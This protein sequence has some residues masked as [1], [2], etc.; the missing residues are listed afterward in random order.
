MKIVTMCRGGNVRS[1]AAKMILSRCLRH[2]VIAIG[3]D[4]TN[5]DTKRFLFNWADRIVIMHPDLLKYVSF[6]YFD[7][8]GGRP[9]LD[10][11]YKTT[12]L[13]VGNDVWGNP[14][15][16]NLQTTIVSLINSNVYSPLFDEKEGIID[17]AEVIKTL[18]E[19]KAKLE[20]RNI[21]FD[22]DKQ[23]IKRE[24]AYE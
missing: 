17:L 2:E 22:I 14:F 4:N 6:T 1:V 8:Y 9:R 24:D 13:N 20:L 19:Y 10:Y 21:R 5:Y 23:I 11:T 15:N 3:A 18:R 16:E 12:L 7:N